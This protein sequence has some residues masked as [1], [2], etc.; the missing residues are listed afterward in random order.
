[1]DLEDA[2]TNA[3]YQWI[4]ISNNRQWQPPL[5]AEIIRN[6][7]GTKKC[8]YMGMYYITSVESYAKQFIIKGEL[9]LYPDIVYNP[10]DNRYRRTVLKSPQFGLRQEIFP[11]VSNFIQ[12]RRTVFGTQGVYFIGELH[13]S[14]GYVHWNVMIIDYTNQLPVVRFFDPAASQDRK[15]GYDFHSRE[16]LMH[17]ISRV[18]SPVVQRYEMFSP[19]ER[20]QTYCQ[21]GSRYIDAFCHSWCLIFLDAYVNDVEAEFLALPFHLHQT[22]FVKAWTLCWMKKLNWIQWLPPIPWWG[23]FQKCVYYDAANDKVKVVDSEYLCYNTNSC[24]SSLIDLV[25]VTKLR[26]R[27]S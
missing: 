11:T 4:S 7:R 19:V 13:A 16:I 3:N 22:G 8:V 12:S 1:M 2:I 26:P 21:T 14:D 27:R 17:E 5:V 25:K 6:G 20:P 23:L 10:Q 15:S 9:D 24:I 18:Y